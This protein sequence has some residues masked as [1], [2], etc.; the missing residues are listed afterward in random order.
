MNIDN[1]IKTEDGWYSFVDKL[2]CGFK[3]S[4]NPYNDLLYLFIMGGYDDNM[5]YQNTLFNSFLHKGT[6]VELLFNKQ[7]NNVL[8]HNNSVVDCMCSFHKSF[9][10]VDVFNNAFV[11]MYMWHTFKLDRFNILFNVLFTAYLKT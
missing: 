3:I 9:R 4:G 11:D 6:S 7:F 2:N 1:N 5:D 8:Q 10:Q